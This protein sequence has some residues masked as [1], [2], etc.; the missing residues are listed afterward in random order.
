MVLAVVDGTNEG[1]MLPRIAGGAD[2]RGRGVRAIRT[3]LVLDLGM[4]ALA[5]IENTQMLQ[6]YRSSR[7]PIGRESAGACESAGSGDERSLERKVC[8]LRHTESTK[9]HR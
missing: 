1:N 9:R 7:D 5:N 4:D 3:S 6:L 8:E 2:G